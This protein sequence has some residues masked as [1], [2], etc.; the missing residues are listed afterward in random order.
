MTML[1]DDL[2]LVDP[3]VYEFLSREIQ[4]LLN[5]AKTFTPFK[6]EIEYNNFL[7]V[8]CEADPPVDGTVRIHIPRQL[9]TRLA[10]ISALFYK[11]RQAQGKN[12]LNLFQQTADIQDVDIDF[13]DDAARREYIDRHRRE[14]SN[15][16]PQYG[17]LVGSFNVDIEKNGLDWWVDKYGRSEMEQFIHVRQ[18]RERFRHAILFLFCH[19]LMHVVLGHVAEYDMASNNAVEDEKRRRRFELEADMAG[20][21]TAFVF[22]LLRAERFCHINSIKE[23]DIRRTHLLCSEAHAVVEGMAFALSML[24]CSRMWESD[25]RHTNYFPPA[26]RLYFATKSWHGILKDFGGGAVLVRTFFF[27]MLEDESWWFRTRTLFDDTKSLLDLDVAANL[28]HALAQAAVHSYCKD[29]AM[30][31]AHNREKLNLRTSI[32]PFN[33]DQLSDIPRRIEDRMWLYIDRRS[34]FIERAFLFV[35]NPSFILPEHD[36]GPITLL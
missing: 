8:R 13:R 15:M 30:F 26:T 3:E 16:P 11:T 29:V 35:T 33:L 5:N 4:I 27:D 25:F 1:G 6:V 31:W 10:L 18:L 20:F 19:E 17:Q 23:G 2:G 28:G 32:F 14:I 21:L 12:V 34:N 7:S 22:A 9:I 36:Y 24:D